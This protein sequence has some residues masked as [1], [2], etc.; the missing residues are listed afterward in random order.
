[1][2][3]AATE[4]P[5]SLEDVNFAQHRVGMNFWRAENFVFFV[6]VSSVHGRV[7]AW[8]TGRVQL[9]IVTERMKAQ[10]RPDKGV[11]WS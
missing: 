11:T 7:G 4:L 3:R 8:H 6:A 10:S 9:L 2:I 5:G 1:M